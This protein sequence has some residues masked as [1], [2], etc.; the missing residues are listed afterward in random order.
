MLSKMRMITALLAE[1]LTTQRRMMTTTKLK[2]ML[3]RKRKG[4]RLVLTTKMR[5]MAERS[6]HSM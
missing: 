5:D 2:E 6:R 1:L 3:K 4:H